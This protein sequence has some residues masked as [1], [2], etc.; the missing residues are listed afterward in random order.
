M[1]AKYHCGRCGSEFTPEPAY[2]GGGQLC[3]RCRDKMQPK[4]DRAREAF[5]EVGGD[6]FRDVTES[7]PSATRHCSECGKR[8][9]EFSLC[10]SCMAK[11]DKERER[12]RKEEER[13]EQRRRKEYEKRLRKLW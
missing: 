12:K 11:A 3:R 7:L 5:E 4:F 8:I 6:F 2:L 1:S 9:Y 10:E 13:E